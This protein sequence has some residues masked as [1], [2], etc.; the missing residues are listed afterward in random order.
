MIIFLQ[1]VFYARGFVVPYIIH[2]QQIS[3]FLVEP[4]KQSPKKV[5]KC[6]AVLRIIKI[7][8]KF[9]AAGQSPKSNQFFWAPEKCCP[10][11]FPTRK[12]YFFVRCS[13]LKASFV[14]CYN[15]MTQILRIEFFLKSFLNDFTFAGSFL[16]CFA[17]GVTLEKSSRCSNLWMCLAEYL[18]LAVCSIKSENCLVS[19]EQ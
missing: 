11:R 15:L 18:F 3:F 4:A 12:P 9:V 2:H 7:I 17:L 19:I 8:V 13:E 6:Q 14:N 16:M 5:L 10:W 1:K